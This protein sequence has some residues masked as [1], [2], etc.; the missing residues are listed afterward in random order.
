MR[1]LLLLLALCTWGLAHAAGDGPDAR[2]WPGASLD[3]FTEYRYVGSPKRDENGKIIRSDEVTKAFMAIHPCPSTGLREGE[4][5][6][7]SMDHVVSLACGGADAVWNLQWLHKSV[8]SAAARPG[9]YPK[10]R[11]ERKVY[12]ADPP[13]ADTDNCTFVTP[14]RTLQ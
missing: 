10:D 11:I 4:C 14:E 5:P 7:W 2:G 13:I 3:P 9:F 12:G 1:K 8:K 6:D